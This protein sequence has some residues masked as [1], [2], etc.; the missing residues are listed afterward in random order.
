[1]YYESTEARNRQ[2]RS[3]AA[4]QKVDGLFSVPKTVAAKKK[5]LGPFAHPG[6]IP[7]DHIL[8]YKEPCVRVVHQAQLRSWSEDLE[9]S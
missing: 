4:I 9:G 1:M 6:S 2:F 5:E 8:L 7:G 3:G